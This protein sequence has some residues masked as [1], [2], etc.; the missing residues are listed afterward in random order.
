MN[1]K[2]YHRLTIAIASEVPP[3]YVSNALRANLDASFL[4]IAE[5][6]R[7]SEMTLQ[8]FFKEYEQ[9]ASKRRKEL[10]PLLRSFLK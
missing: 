2:E 9:I 6:Y 5:E 8:E 7:N 1:A 4:L 3:E 10:E